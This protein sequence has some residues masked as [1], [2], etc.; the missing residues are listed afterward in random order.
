MK[1]Y[2]LLVRS[3]CWFLVIYFVGG[4]LGALTPKHEIFPVSSWFLFPVTPNPDTKFALR[5]YRVEGK[6]LEP[7]RFY[8]EADG[9]V[10]DPRSI[11]VYE[12]VQM[13]GKAERR[14]DL[15]VIARIRRI[16]DSNSV[17]PPCRYELVTVTYDPVERWK[18]GEV[19]IETIEMYSEGET[20]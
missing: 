2:R 14:G 16:I 5:L 8:E 1:R 7:P 6:T 12:A 9:I 19:Q 15:P 3:I 4:L 18:T 11:D 17:M 10:S 13:L 20:R